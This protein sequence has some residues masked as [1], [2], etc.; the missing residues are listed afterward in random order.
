[1]LGVSEWLAEEVRH[2]GVDVRYS[3]Y[4]EHETIIGLDPDVAVIATGGLP[5]LEWLEGHEHCDS[6][7]DILGGGTKVRDSVLLYD[8]LGDHAGASCAEV[9][10]DE[11]ATVELAFRGH[12][13]AQR[14]G[15]CNYPMYLKHFYEKGIVLTPDL[16]LEKVQKCGQQLRSTFQNEL[17]GQAEERM[18]GQVVVE[19]GTIPLDGLYEA[20]KAGSCN[21]GSVDMDK[22]LAGRPQTSPLGH[23]DGYE[24]YRVGDA[25]SCRDIHAAILDSRRLCKDL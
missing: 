16:R 1:M 12:H 18:T 9:L 4:A 25:V 10:A 13:A 5:D 24:L 6:V 11:G 15:Y 3:V 23:G 7:W 17:T 21:N 19:R 14:S 22:L 8:E 2:L 20:L